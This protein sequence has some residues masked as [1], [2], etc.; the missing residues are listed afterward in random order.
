MRIVYRLPSALREFS[1]KAPCNM[2]HDELVRITTSCARPLPRTRHVVLER[3][4]KEAVVIDWLATPPTTVTLAVRL[5]SSLHTVR[6]RTKK[7]RI[8]LM[9]HAGPIEIHAYAR[10]NKPVVNGMSSS[11][12][13]H[14]LFANVM[15]YKRAVERRADG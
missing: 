2:N 4:L 15:S 6:S 8:Q 9:I 12:A 7:A 10:Q 1:Q 3:S 11:P 5:L 13:N 14:N